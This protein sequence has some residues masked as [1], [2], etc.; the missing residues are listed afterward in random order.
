[1]Q[2][3][4][5][6]T[7]YKSRVS[8][9]KYSS[10]EIGLNFLQVYNSLDFHQEIADLHMGFLHFQKKRLAMQEF[11]AL[12]IALWGMALRRSFPE[13]CAVFFADFLANAA[14]L[15]AKAQAGAKLRSRVNIYSDLLKLHGES[16]FSPVA[17]YITEILAVSTT[18]LP[19]VRLKLSLNI[20]ALYD[21]IFTRLC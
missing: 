11:K 19:S 13:D 8:I 7:E 17:Q 20:R 5:N 2:T 12:S 9:A 14:F 4:V 3:T 15:Q 18:D 21:F 10:E 6:P 16:N 1:M